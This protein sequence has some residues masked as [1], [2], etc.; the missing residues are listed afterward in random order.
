MVCTVLHIHPGPSLSSL[1]PSR[2]KLL[3]EAA[4]VLFC[5]GVRKY[6][7]SMVGDFRKGKEEEP[8]KRQLRC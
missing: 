6:V 4:G 7:S 3:A 8:L 2:H 1:V 5:L